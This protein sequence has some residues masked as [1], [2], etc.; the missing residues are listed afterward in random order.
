MI[1][2]GGGVRSR[3]K[4][5]GACI[6]RQRS[7]NSTRQPTSTSITHGVLGNFDK[8]RHERTHRALPID[9]TLGGDAD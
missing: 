6:E 4:V 1:R 8:F 3:V 7:M 9:G 2:G 5:D